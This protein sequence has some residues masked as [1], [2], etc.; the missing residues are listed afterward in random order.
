VIR[1]SETPLLMRD[2]KLNGKYIKSLRK[3][4]KSDQRLWSAKARP[5]RLC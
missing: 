5:F 4:L 1:L 3:V 2:I